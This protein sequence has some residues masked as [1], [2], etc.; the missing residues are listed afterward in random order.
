MNKKVAV[1]TWCSPD[2]H[3]FI[4]IK[5]L[6]NSIKYFHPEIDH[7]VNSEPWSPEKAWFLAPACMQVADNYDMV[8]HIDGDAVVVGDLSEMIS[9]NADVIG[10]RNNNAFNKAG[11]N[12]GITTPHHVYNSESSTYASTDTQILLEEWLNAG[13]IAANNKNFWQ[14]W[15]EINMTV[16]GILKSYNLHRLAPP[17]GDEN[18]TLN[19]VYFSDRFT[20]ETIDAKGTNLH[21]N[22]SNLWSDGP[23]N[24]YESWKNLYIKDEKVFL[25]DPIDGTPNQVKILHQAG[26][27]YAARLNKEHGG[28][29]KW[30][31]QVVPPEI[32]DYIDHITQ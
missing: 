30:L 29:R 16:R 3:E 19:L 14:A 28:F 12:A 7:H 21:Y 6:T 27:D 17:Y 31:R 15:H 24:H 23:Y 11:G 20:T 13:I 10:T 18:D 5:E 26:G 32:R 2:Y 22:I 25:D 9:S 4:G 1:S 8:I